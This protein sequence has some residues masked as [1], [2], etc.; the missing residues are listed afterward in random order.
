MGC[1]D[2]LQLAA[3]L[4]HADVENPLRSVAASQNKLQAESGLSGAGFAL[5]QVKTPGSKASAEDVVETC[6]PRRG[7]VAARQFET[8][9]DPIYNRTALTSLLRLAFFSP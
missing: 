4:R 6:Q 1:C 2:R 5:D 3:C 7:S 8:P 9:D